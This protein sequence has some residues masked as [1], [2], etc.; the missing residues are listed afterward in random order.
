[1]ASVA[2][3]DIVAAVDIIDA[4]HKP[5]DFV[6]VIGIVQK[7]LAPILTRARRE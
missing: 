3:A 6:N 5:G 1:M 2:P 4:K 7:A